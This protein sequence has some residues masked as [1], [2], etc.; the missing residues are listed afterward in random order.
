MLPDTVYTLDVL[1]AIGR[2]GQLEIPFQHDIGSIGPVLSDAEPQVKLTPRTKSDIGHEE[3]SHFKQ[4]VERTLRDPAAVEEP[5]VVEIGRMDWASLDIKPPVLLNFA[6]P[7]ATVDKPSMPRRPSVGSADGN[8]RR[9]SDSAS[10]VGSVAIGP[11][12]ASFALPASIPRSNSSTSLNPFAPPFPLPAKIQ[13]APSL[14]MPM[15]SSLPKRPGAL[16][17]VFVKKESATLPQPMALPAVP[18]LGHAWDGVVSGNERR[19][20]RSI[21]SEMSMGDRSS[22][23]RPERLK[24]LGNSLRASTVQRI[25]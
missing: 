21:S 8:W 19:R 4:D 1:L 10:S 6:D 22:D 2:Q 24:S 20:A 7:F 25:L 13:D 18:S 17:P 15:P 23:S 14:P 16:P 3:R 12:R 5:K 9:R 11:V